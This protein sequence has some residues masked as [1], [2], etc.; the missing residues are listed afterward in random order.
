MVQA[1][2][3]TRNI[4]DTLII[5]KQHYQALG[6]CIFSQIVGKEFIGL[7]EKGGEDV[8]HLSVVVALLLPPP[9]HQGLL[10]QSPFLQEALL[11]PYLLLVT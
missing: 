9:V 5:Q 10:L 1:T 3:Q 8:K 4:K 6:T 11:Q 2:D 7:T